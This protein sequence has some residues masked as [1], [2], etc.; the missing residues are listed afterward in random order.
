MYL[1][2]NYFMAD[3][4]QKQYSSDN[5]ELEVALFINELG[6]RELGFEQEFYL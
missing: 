1:A 5:Q 3:W 2:H 4:F 6:V